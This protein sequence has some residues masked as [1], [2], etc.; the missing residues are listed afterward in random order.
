LCLLAG[1]LGGTATALSSVLRQI[2]QTP[3]WAAAALE[4]TPQD[5]TRISHV[6]TTAREIRSALAKPIPGPQPLPPITAKLAYG[7]LM[8]GGK[9]AIS[10]AA[11]RK[12][13]LP[14]AALDA[15]AMDVSAT[16]FRAGSAVIPELHKVY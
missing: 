5:T 13:R 4:S 1:L 2:H 3:A 8:P 14:K 11:P 9:G 10:I 7:Y 6:V 12:P 15:M 16:N